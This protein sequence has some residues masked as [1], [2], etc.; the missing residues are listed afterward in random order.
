MI[1][2]K[3]SQGAKQ[4]WQYTMAP[5]VTPEMQKHVVCQLTRCISPPHHSSFYSR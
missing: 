3:L 2:I 5:K 1:E 4:A